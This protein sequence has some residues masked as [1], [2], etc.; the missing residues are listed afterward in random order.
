[1]NKKEHWQ[2]ILNEFEQS[3]QGQRDFCINKKISVHTF[4]Y[5]KRKFSSNQLLALQK[6]DFLEIKRDTNTIE[7]NPQVTSDFLQIRSATGM[8]LKINLS[9]LK[10]LFK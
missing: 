1:M 5:W 9:I 2:K 10:L 7:A 4:L 6:S 3:G 8:E